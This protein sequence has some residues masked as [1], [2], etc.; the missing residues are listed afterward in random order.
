MYFA[1]VEDRCY[2]SSHNFIYYSTLQRLNPFSNQRVSALFITTQYARRKSGTFSTLSSQNPTLATTRFVFHVLFQ[3]PPVVHSALT[4]FFP[5]IFFSFFLILCFRHSLYIYH[6]LYLYFSSYYFFWKFR[7][8]YSLITHIPSRLLEDHMSSKDDPSGS[9][10]PPES[11]RRPS[12]P[13]IQS[14]FGLR[15]EG[16]FCIMDCSHF[17]ILH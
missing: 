1:Q 3:L 13:S 16:E 15:R 8:L 4:T 14:L 11:S 17:T 9:S 7:S 10:S 12:L 6:L 5:L 2:L